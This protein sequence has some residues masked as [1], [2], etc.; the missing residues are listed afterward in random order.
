MTFDLI[1]LLEEELRKTI[2]DKKERHLLQCER[3]LA[4]F[5]A[6]FHRLPVPAGELLS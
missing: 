5:D 3:S 4:A 2:R 1:E 6:G